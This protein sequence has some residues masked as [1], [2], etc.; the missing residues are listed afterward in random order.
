MQLL[1]CQKLEKKKKKH[2]KRGNKKKRKE[3]EDV[4]NMV[5]FVF[6]LIIVFYIV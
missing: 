3:K 2:K 4:E 5:A 1:A 6:N